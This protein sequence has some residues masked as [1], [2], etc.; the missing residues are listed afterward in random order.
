MSNQQKPPYQWMQRQDMVDVVKEYNRIAS[1]HTWYIPASPELLEAIMFVE[2]KGK[3]VSYGVRPDGTISGAMGV[4]QVKP[5]SLPT[6]G[7]P[8][9]L[10]ARHDF[11]AAYQENPYDSALN[12]TAALS[13]LMEKSITLQN[14]AGNGGKFPTEQMEGNLYLLLLGYKAGNDGL[15][16]DFKALEPRE[17][18]QRNRV[19]PAKVAAYAKFMAGQRIDASPEKALSYQDVYTRIIDDVSRLGA[20]P[21]EQ[22]ARM[23]AFIRQVEQAEHDYQGKGDFALAISTPFAAPVHIVPNECQALLAAVGEHHRDYVTQYL[24][25]QDIHQ[26]SL[27]CAV[28]EDSKAMFN[29]TS[30]IPCADA[31]ATFCREWQLRQQQGFDCMLE[32]REDSTNHGLPKNAPLLANTEGR[33]K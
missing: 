22:T 14:Y 30:I 2:S 4:M 19:Y 27:S 28:T 5:D 29:S 7:V 16:G 12:L 10:F 3:P 21:K 26:F 18:L 13:V 17:E 31:V 23:K 33:G 6:R 20:N 8:T 25:P 24:N 11:H 9:L 15:K 1:D 32:I